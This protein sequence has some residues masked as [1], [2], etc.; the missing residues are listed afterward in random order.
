MVASNKCYYRRMGIY[1][2][3][4]WKHGN[5]TNLINDHHVIKG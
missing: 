1:N 5:K 4:N 2:Q 3:K